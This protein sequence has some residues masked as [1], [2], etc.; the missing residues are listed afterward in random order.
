MDL[1]LIGAGG[2]ARVVLDILLV[3]NEHRIV[4]AL[5]ADPALVG[6][7]IHG[8]EVLGPIQL[9]EKLR[10]QQHA[11]GAI[12]AIGDN[13]VR[14]GYLRE[15]DMAGL[16]AVNA[17]HP[18]SSVSP[19]ATLGRNVVICAG[20]IVCIGAQIGDSTIL[21]TGCRVDHECVVGEAAHL[22]PN[23]TLA[24]RV[25]VG[26]EAFIGMG[27]NVIQCRSIGD[28]AMIAAGAVV[29]RDVAA[30]A[31]VAGVPARLMR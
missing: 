6:T 1:V 12:V 3:R 30:G 5:D 15:L 27:A 18:W 16:E 19:R 14:R 9:L 13:R 22:A 29:T 23:A 31:R 10:R 4:G 24:G 17:I 11:R 28:G 21:N 25:T 7:K 8:V 2:H 20:A 26:A